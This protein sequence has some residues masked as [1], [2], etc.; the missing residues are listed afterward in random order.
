MYQQT[1]FLPMPAF[2]PPDRRRWMARSLECDRILIGLETEC[3]PARR[4][5]LRRRLAAL[6]P[7]PTRKGGRR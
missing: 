2:Y 5:A 7:R 6:Q 3:R 4:D 1:S